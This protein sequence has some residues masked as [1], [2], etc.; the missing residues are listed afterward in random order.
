MF[1][2]RPFC[3]SFF[4]R[5]RCWAWLA[6]IATPRVPSTMSFTSLKSGQPASRRAPSERK[7]RVAPSA[8]RAIS[9]STGI[10]PARSGVH[11]MRQP[12]TDGAF[13]A[14]V[15]SRVSTA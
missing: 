13:T 3:I 2:T 9:S 5:G 1:H 6:T 12:L 15:N 10:R 11:A 7:T 14:C 4:Q 8:T